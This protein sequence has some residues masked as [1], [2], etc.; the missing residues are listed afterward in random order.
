VGVRPGDL[1]SETVSELPGNA[2]LLEPSAASDEKEKRLIPQ[3]LLTDSDRR[4]LILHGFKSLHRHHQ[5]TLAYNPAQTGDI[6]MRRPPRL[7]ATL[8]LATGCVT[9][10]KD[11]VVVSVTRDALA[12]KDCKFLGN[13]Q[14]D[15]QLNGDPVGKATAEN[16]PPLSAT[17]YMRNKAI[18]MG[19][20][21][22][23]LVRGTASGSND[24]GEAYACPAAPSA[25]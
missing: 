7:I 19:A 9:A 18:A 5:S 14:G 8:A 6:S 4:R 11:T 24:F 3:A 16:K 17:A 1:V 22:I 20:N 23:L 21:T 15:D 25:P 10:D 13:L 12:L 2:R